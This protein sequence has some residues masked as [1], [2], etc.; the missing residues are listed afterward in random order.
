MRGGRAS[1]GGDNDGERAGRARVDLTGG[2]GEG[3]ERAAARQP[4]GRASGGGDNGRRGARVAA[5]LR[6]EA[7]TAGRGRAGRVS[8]SP[9]AGEREGEGGGA[10]AWRRASGGG[11][12]GL[13]AGVEGGAS[14]RE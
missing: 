14:G 1:G 3:G 5:G 6:A 11:D 10:A 4:G 13:A 12:N 2:R 8:I 7:T 9:V